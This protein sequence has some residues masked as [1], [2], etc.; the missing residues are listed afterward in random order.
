MINRPTYIQGTHCT[1]KP[2]EMARNN[3]ENIGNLE[4]LPKTQGNTWNLV[5]SS[6]KLHDSKGES[7]F[8]ICHEN[9]QIFFKFNKSAESVLCM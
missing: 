7:Y 1:G 9:L 2:G 4:I 6:C 8:E 3:R 5:C